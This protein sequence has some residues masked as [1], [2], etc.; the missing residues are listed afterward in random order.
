MDAH[1]RRGYALFFVSLLSAAGSYDSEPKYGQMMSVSFLRR[2]ESSMSL[3][4]RSRPEYL[5]FIAEAKHIV[6][7][8]NEVSEGGGYEIW[9]LDAL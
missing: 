7:S 2:T 1:I 5:A 6:C 9:A 3:T 8:S 4:G